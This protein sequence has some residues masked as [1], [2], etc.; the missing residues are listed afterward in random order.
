MSQST[1]QNFQ[2]QYHRI[3]K[4][5][6]VPVQRTCS[7]RLG[8]HLKKMALWFLLGLVA[9][10]IVGLFA[11]TYWITPGKG[12]LMVGIFLDFFILGAL[13]YLYIA[14]DG[15]VYHFLKRIFYVF[16]NPRL[17][18]FDQSMSQMSRAL[19]YQ[20]NSPYRFILERWFSQVEEWGEVEIARLDQAV[21]H[22]RS[23]SHDLYY[24]CREFGHL[25][26]DDQQ[27]A[28]DFWQEHFQPYVEEGRP[29]YLLSGQKSWEDFKPS[30]LIL[31]AKSKLDCQTKTITPTGFTPPPRRL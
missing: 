6:N 1:L 12:T 8:V 15:R 22:F 11:F 16:F 19:F 14:Y 10:F 7:F 2:N 24:Y 23:L 26:S 29:S 25:P 3:F 5:L 18:N 21:D 13:L 17:E 20:N 31:H 30:G 28:W 27:Q 9:Y 4:Q